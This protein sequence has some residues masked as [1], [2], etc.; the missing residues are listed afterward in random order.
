MKQPSVNLGDAMPDT[1]IGLKADSAIRSRAEKAASHLRSLVTAHRNEAVLLFLLVLTIWLVLNWHA[2]IQRLVHYYTALPDWDYWRVVDDFPQFKSLHF[3]FL[4]RQHVDHRIIFPEIVFQLDM[5]L[6]HGYQFLPLAVSFVSYFLTWLTIARALLSDAGLSR[7]IRATAVLLSGIVIGWE[8]CTS[9]LGWPFLLNWTLVQFAAILSL[10]WLSLAGE[11]KRAGNFWFVLAIAAA[12]VANYSSANGLTLWPILIAFML[13]VPLSK[14]KRIALSA[15]AAVSIGI[16]FVGFR[17]SNSLNLEN[18]YRHPLY[19]I[20]Y[21]SSY[22]SMPFGADPSPW[23]GVCI[24][25]ASILSAALLLILT[26]R[27]GLLSTRSAVVLFGSY[28]FAFL[29]AVLTAAGR[30]NYPDPSFASAKVPRYLSVPIVG[31]AVLISLFLWLAGR[32][33]LKIAP[34]I[35][36]VCFAFLLAFGFSNLSR[37]VNTGAEPFVDVQEAILGLEDGLAMPSLMRRLYPNENDLRRDLAVIKADHLSIYYRPRTKWLGLPGSRFGRRLD[38]FAA[39]EIT[40]VL[41]TPFGTEISGWADDEKDPIRYRWILLVNEADRIVGFGERVPAQVAQDPIRRNWI[42]F[43]SPQIKSSS[44]RAYLVSPAG[45]S[46]LRGS[47][48]TPVLA[49]VNP[50]YFG[51]PIA[52]IHWQLDPNLRANTI[53]SVIR[54]AISLPGPI[55][56]T[57]SGSDSNTGQIASSAFDATPDH[58]IVFPVLHGPSVAGLSVGIW[59]AANNSLIDTIPMLHPDTQWEFWRMRVPAGVE[60]LRITADDHGHGWGQWLAIGQPSRCR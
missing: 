17:F 1:A 16:Y 8:G 6:W 19:S 58:C 49:L 44:Y 33:R 54:L 45:L 56:S 53:P 20:G 35:I 5:L 12:I 51:S 7:T 39:G 22:M 47:T 10:G 25:L 15:S 32:R 21:I 34:P 9:V 46:P 2:T 26:A 57:W 38:D 43:A 24:G 59:D 4:W 40:K 28:A 50:Q 31:W 55:Y 13:V 41:P 37:W 60:R 29:T 48:S 27:A 14:K 18:F 52:G 30:M 3:Q 36:A 23:V 11:K 42:G